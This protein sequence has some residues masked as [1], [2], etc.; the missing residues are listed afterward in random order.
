MKLEGKT[1]IITS[2][3]SVFIKLT[4]LLIENSGKSRSDFII[5]A[6]NGLPFKDRF[7]KRI[8]KIGLLPALD[9]LLYT[10]YEA[11][12]NHWKKAERKLFS[13][14]DITSFSPDILTDTVNKRSVSILDSLKTFEVKNIISIG[15]GFIPTR[16]LEQFN[17]KINIHPGILPYYKGI[18]SPEAIMRGDLSFLGWSIHELATKI[19]SGS[20]IHNHT[21]S[22]KILEKMTFAEVYITI[23]RSAIINFYLTINNSDK[24]EMNFNS[25]TKYFAFVRFTLFIKYKFKPVHNSV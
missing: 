3:S 16:L 20:I 9:E 8:E 4:K 15:S 12:F 18:G 24:S 1:V 19:D 10:S 21:I 22:F 17:L 2:N 5:I 7:R 11:L 25:N 13:D 6:E 14:T 23:Y